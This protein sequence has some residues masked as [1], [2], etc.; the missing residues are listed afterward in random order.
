MYA[1]GYVHVLVLA[2]SSL[3]KY[4]RAWLIC[5]CLLLS[6]PKALYRLK[7]F[8]LMCVKIF[9]YDP[10]TFHTFLEQLVEVFLLIF[11]LK[12]FY[13]Q[14]TMKASELIFWDRLAFYPTEMMTRD[15]SSPHLYS[16]P[17]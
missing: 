4:I 1:F 5:I 15:S 10:K 17:S 11:L 9:F 3:G 16:S 6:F 2:L 7:C 13:L 8:I 14:Y 12:C